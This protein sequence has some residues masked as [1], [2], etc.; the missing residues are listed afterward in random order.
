ML[1]SVFLSILVLIQWKEFSDFEETL[2]KLEVENR[3]YKQMLDNIK[4]TP[5]VNCPRFTSEQYLPGNSC[6]CAG[7]NIQ[8]CPFYVPKRS[9]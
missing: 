4:N 7:T 3:R 1:L 6:M 2:L 9:I 8:L 5:K